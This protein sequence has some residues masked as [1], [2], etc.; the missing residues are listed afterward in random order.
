MDGVPVETQGGGQTAA[1][2]WQRDWKG[3]K[4][5]SGLCGPAR[6]EVRVVLQRLPPGGQVPPRP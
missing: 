6:A 1:G 3:V 5:G 2:V 4:A